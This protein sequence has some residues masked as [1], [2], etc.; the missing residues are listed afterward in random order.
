MFIKLV[1]KYLILFFFYYIQTE[2]NDIF[3]CF[4]TFHNLKITF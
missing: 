4:C 1:E 2:A 3:N